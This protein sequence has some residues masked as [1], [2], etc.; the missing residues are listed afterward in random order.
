MSITVAGAVPEHELPS[1][2]YDV[3]A[4]GSVRK[5]YE[6][7]QYMTVLLQDYQVFCKHSQYSPSSSPR[8]HVIRRSILSR[9]PEPSHTVQEPSQSFQDFFRQLPCSYRC[10]PQHT[11]SASTPSSPRLVW[12]PARNSHPL[13]L[14]GGP[15]PSSI[16]IS[17][18]STQG[19][20]VPLLLGR[21]RPPIDGFLHWPRPHSGPT[22][23]ATSI[24]AGSRPHSHAAHT[25]RPR[26]GRHASAPSFDHLVTSPAP[27]RTPLH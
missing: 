17:L 16:K 18:L 5:C 12:L 10:R 20:S 23:T 8:L 26:L 7:L 13:L 22:L 21:S 1:E 3:M 11:A 24:R 4:P 6:P 25:A 14:C 19:S 2:Y 15:S 27:T 9:S